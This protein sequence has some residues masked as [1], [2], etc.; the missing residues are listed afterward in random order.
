MLGLGSEEDSRQKGVP[1]GVQSSK[2]GRNFDDYET[3]IPVDSDEEVEHEDE[4]ARKIKAMKPYFFVITLSF[5]FC[6][7][8][9]FFKGTT[10]IS[11]P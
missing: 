8:S 5:F 9:F 10:Q 11:T 1:L 3:S 6:I 7:G 4:L 2:G